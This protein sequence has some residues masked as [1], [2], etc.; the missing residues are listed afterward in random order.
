MAIG[1]GLLP[2]RNFPIRYARN[3][4]IIIEQ[5]I[6]GCFIAYIIIR[7]A[8]CASVLTDQIMKPVAGWGLLIYQVIVVQS[9]QTPTRFSH[10]D[11]VESRD[12]IGIESRTRMQSARR[13]NMRCWPAD[14][15]R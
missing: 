8:Q 3:V 13:R 12:S 7:G 14:R 4:K 9:F 2:W 5:P 15:S 10:V 6:D 1:S 11:I